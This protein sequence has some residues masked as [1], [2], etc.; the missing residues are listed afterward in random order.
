MDNTTKKYRRFKHKINLFTERLSFNFLNLD[1]YKKISLI[2]IIISFVALFFNW[3]KINAEWLN[4]FSI[5]S[6]YVWYI[7]FLILGFSSFIMLSSNNKEKLKTKINIFFY[8][9][10]IV[11]FSWIIIFLLTFSIFNSINWL[12][13]FTQD[14]NIWGWIVFELIWSIFITAWW[15]FSY[16]ANKKE[17][18]HKL[19]IENI[20]A[21]EDMEEYNEILNKTSSKNMKLPI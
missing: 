5:N 18:L 13:R 21:N 10:T 14:I 3:S 17:I 6:W 9:Y 16:K 12:V 15:V 20:K 19:Y 2:W 4:S 11:T 8:D 7:I 1:V